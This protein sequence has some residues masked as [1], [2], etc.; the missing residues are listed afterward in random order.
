MAVTVDT[1]TIG[2]GAHTVEASAPFRS[3]MLHEVHARCTCGWRTVG[4]AERAEEAATTAW[5]H[6]VGH[7]ASALYAERPAALT[8]QPA[9]RW[10]RLLRH[11]PAPRPIRDPKDRSWLI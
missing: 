9:G 2:T 5:A 7:T 6:A 4:I 11:W 1:N 3:G 10:R 8:K